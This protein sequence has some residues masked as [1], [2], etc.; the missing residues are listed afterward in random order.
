MKLRVRKKSEKQ[1]LAHVYQSNYWEKMGMLATSVVLS[2]LPENRTRPFW[3]FGNLLNVR[4]R[5]KNPTV[6]IYK[7][8]KS[9]H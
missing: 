6:P 8:E 9:L 7:A 1:D 4:K 3:K 5:V 2:G